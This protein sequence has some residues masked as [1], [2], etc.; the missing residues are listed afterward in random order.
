M[1]QNIKLS[2]VN[3]IQR[4]DIHKV[5]TNIDIEDVNNISKGN[6]ELTPAQVHQFEIGYSSFKPGLMTNFALYYKAKKNVIE[7]FTF[8]RDDGVN[9]TN[10]L[11]TGDNNSFGFNFYGSTTIG[12]NL[13]LRGSVDIYTYNMSTSINDVSLL[14]SLIHI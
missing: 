3:R 6:P 12:K 9:E 10:Y 5:N 14:L 2:Y 8:V 4:P 11:N 1:F 7:A 13:T